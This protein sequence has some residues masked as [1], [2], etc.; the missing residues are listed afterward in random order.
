[1]SPLPTPP[2][3]LAGNL[4]VGLLLAAIAAGLLHLQPS[5]GGAWLSISG[6]P[7][8][9]AAGIA[10]SAWLALCAGIVWKH[11]VPRRRETAGESW[12]I[13]WASQTGFA[14][15][16]AEASA[17]ALRANGHAACCLPLERIDAT[18]L[19][20]ARHAL[21]IVSTT[22]EGD[23]PDHAL[24]FLHGPMAGSL[25][26]PQLH[27]AV[28]ALGDRDY[29]QFCAFGHRLDAWLASCGATALFERI[30]VDN[31]APAAIER[32]QRQL[33]RLGARS[34]AIEWEA[35][36]APWC[37]RDRRELNPGARNGAVHALSLQPADGKLPHWLAGDIAEIR[38][39]NAVATVD[40]W[41]ADAAFDG[42]APID[43][44]GAWTLREHLLHQQLPVADAWRDRPLPALLA[45]LQPLPHREYSI[46]SIP[47]SG[48]LDLLVRAVSA[49]DGTPGLGSGWLCRHM[50]AGDTTGL[51]IRSNPGFHP[52]ADDVPMILIG[53]GTGLAGLR[54]HLQARAAAGAHR[55]WL[56][57]GERHVATD[58][59]FADDIRA[60]QA[61]GVLMRFDFALSRDDRHRRYVQ[62]ALRE[63]GDELRRWIADGAVLY[64]CGSLQGMAP[65]VDAVLDEVLG[66]GQRE[67]LL[68]GGRYRRDVY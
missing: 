11:R 23:A 30:D 28:L 3:V 15:Q 48:A 8:W 55:N 38:P 39:C 58:L 21:F 20:G 60:W 66:P 13:A 35:P 61:D 10:L 37:L 17:E 14:R 42:H 62:D 4:L 41:L 45:A 65:G 19:A 53:N 51:R 26:L 12:L 52:P 9:L 47:G 46:A 63:A 2:R 36:F 68:L 29:A 40:R 33:E 56:L 44:E 50:A 18:T 49:P 34:D 64:V 67:A 54:A 43:V 1:M 32:W 59:Y 7:H 5:S 57:F 24:A 31:A 6:H 22:G 27:H 16:L 25:S